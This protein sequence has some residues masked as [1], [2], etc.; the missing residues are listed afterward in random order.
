MGLG[1]NL[2]HD[3][4]GGQNVTDQPDSLALANSSVQKSRLKTA[5]NGFWRCGPWRISSGYFSGGSQNH[6]S[7]SSTESPSGNFGAL[8][9]VVLKTSSIF[10][11]KVFSTCAYLESFD[12]L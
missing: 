8:G 10:A 12:K 6:S 3:L 2:F 11:C 1:D 5:W 4:R 7:F 9:S